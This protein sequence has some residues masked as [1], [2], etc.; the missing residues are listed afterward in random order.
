MSGVPRV[1]EKVYSV[2][3]S[4][5]DEA[6]GAKG[7]ATGGVH[8]PFGMAVLAAGMGGDGAAGAAGT[9]ATGACPG[10]AGG[11]TAHAVAYGK[12]VIQI[13]RFHAASLGQPVDF[14]P[15]ETQG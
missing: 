9:G 13:R 7:S 4:R 15:I 12:N 2:V 11:R 10:L 14:V 5:F 6:T 3:Q 8:S 1:Y